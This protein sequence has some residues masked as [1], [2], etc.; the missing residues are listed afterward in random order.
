MTWPGLHD[1]KQRE[2]VDEI[3]WKL[4]VSSVYTLSHDNISHS[5]ECRSELIC[6]IVLKQALQNLLG[7]IL[8]RLGRTMTLRKFQTSC[9]V[10]SESGLNLTSEPAPP[11]SPSK[12]GSTC[13]TGTAVR[14]PGL[15]S[16]LCPVIQAFSVLSCLLKGLTCT[17][18]LSC[19][20]LPCWLARQ[21]LNKASKSGRFARKGYVKFISSSYSLP[22]KEDPFPA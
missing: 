6:H 12:T 19:L 18:R 20:W 13:A 1:S 4:H 7:S 22:V 9:E 15:W 10:T 5:L 3:S 8:R 11:S 14:V 21:G 2:T 16:F 17:Q